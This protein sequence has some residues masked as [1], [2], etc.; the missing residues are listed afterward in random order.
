[1]GASGSNPNTRQI[2]VTNRETFTFITL[3][4]GRG[5]TVREI[6]VMVF[7]K[8]VISPSSRFFVTRIFSSSALLGKQETEEREIRPAD[9][10]KTLETLFTS[11]TDADNLAFSYIAAK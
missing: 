10:D 8:A 4:V 11:T 7:E 2:R 9:M 3:E 5:A 1:M 6:W